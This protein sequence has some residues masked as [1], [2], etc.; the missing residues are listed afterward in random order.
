MSYLGMTIIVV[1][2][3]DSNDVVHVV[4]M[5]MMM[6]CLKGLAMALTVAACMWFLAKALSVSN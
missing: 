1:H 3:A 4:K 2:N 5:M 6:C